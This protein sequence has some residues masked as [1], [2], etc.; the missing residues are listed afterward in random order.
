[1]GTLSVNK[2]AL[3]LVEELM[4][5]HEYYQVKVSNGPLGSTIV[6][7]GIEAR[8]G[9]EAGRII[10]EI[11]MGG[12]GKASI[13]FE[14]FDG[15]ILPA[16]KVHTDHPVIATMASQYAGWRVKVGKFFALGS[17]PARALSLEPKTLYEKIGY[18]DESDEAVI[19]FETSSKPD[20]SVV[21]Y[22]AGK[23][24]VKPSNLYI[25]LTPTMSL[26]AMVQISGRIV[27]TGIHKLNEI[28]F[29]INRIVYGCGYAPIG[30]P[31][32]DFGRAMGRS[33]DVI[34]YGGV[35]FYGVD[36]EDD[37]A[38]SKFVSETPSSAS[39]DYGRPFHQ[40]F[41]EAGYDF[42]KIDPHLFAPASVTVFNIRTGKVYTAGRVDVGVLSRS[43]GLS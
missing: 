12:L 19:V 29:D 10:T 37:E 20:E 2:L 26:S 43:L 3:N 23:C 15:R 33:N 13:S 5:N 7:A 4:D 18:R 40:I 41:K 22:V 34:L 25:I 16:V 28:G 36:F 11:C 1:M 24:G 6:D 14:S 35:T 31:H 38:L 8:G 42:Y 21:D 30:F 39:R 27:E 32:P 9:F 17:G